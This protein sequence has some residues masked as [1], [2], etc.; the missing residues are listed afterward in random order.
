MKKV[1]NKSLEILL[2]LLSFSISFDHNFNNWILGL[3]YFV[4]VLN[5]ILDKNR[6]SFGFLKNKNWLLISV[7]FVITLFGMIYSDNIAEANKDIIRT[8]PML[9][10]PIL[11]FSIKGFY[12]KYSKL[13]AY[14][15]ILG[16]LSAALVCWLNVAQTMYLNNEPIS[17]LFRHRHLNHQ[18]TEV[19]DVHAS[20]MSLFVI[21]S[22]SIIIYNYKELSNRTKKLG[23]T[24]LV[25][26]IIFLFMLLARA[27]LI[28]F[29]ISAFVYLV[30]NANWRGI[31]ISIAVVGVFF[32]IVIKV[33]D[34]YDY[35]R[36]KLFEQIPLI[37]D[38]NRFSR[39]DRLKATKY[40][41]L[42]NPLLGV[43]TADAQFYRQQ[44]YAETNDT[45]AYN[46][47]FN[48]HNQ[49]F[50]YLDQFGI[51]GGL[52]F[53]LFFIYT[54][55]LAYSNKDYLLIYLT[56]LFFVANLTESMLQ[57]TH[58]IVYFSVVFSVLYAKKD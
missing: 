22:I 25:L 10:T 3:C 17:Y 53:V 23:L 51:I 34:Q 5:Y 42:E 58:G 29:L 57:R 7:F 48:A 21:T 15:L 54:F 44:F 4:I 13:L 41:F 43:G 55:K 27:L 31:L 6:F 36:N 46:R 38:N 30:F 18:L 49:F 8:I 2:F 52:A 19:I 50:E 12:N 33:D 9:V 56:L 47:K 28:F 45:I 11:F 37:G 24:L 16:C 20:Y 40:M 39:F 1:I 14:G 32:T 26:F 35:L